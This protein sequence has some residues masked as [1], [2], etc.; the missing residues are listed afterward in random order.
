MELTTGQKW[1]LG[2]GAVALISV[3]GFIIYRKSKTQLAVS[4]MGDVEMPTGTQGAADL[5]AI[6]TPTE[7]NTGKVQIGHG[8]DTITGI[9]QPAANAPTM[10]IGEAMINAQQISVLA[11]AI[12][13]KISVKY[14]KWADYSAAEKALVSKLNAGGYLFLPPAANRLMAMNDSSLAIKKYGGQLVS[15]MTPENK[16]YVQQQLIDGN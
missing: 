9:K 10:P 11:P 16:V 3:T 1:V 13:G 5:G 15:D 12:G 2:I 6:K 7:M 4:G 8:E 14:K